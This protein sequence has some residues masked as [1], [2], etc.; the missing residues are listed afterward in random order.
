MTQWRAGSLN[1]LEQMEHFCLIAV[2][3]TS[4]MQFF[5]CATQKTGSPTQICERLIQD[6]ARVVPRIVDGSHL[7]CVND[8]VSSEDTAKTALLTVLRD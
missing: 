4:F 5:N 1:L 6:T 8:R 7:I 2:M 3:K